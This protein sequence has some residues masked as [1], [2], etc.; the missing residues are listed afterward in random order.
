[1]LWKERNSI[2]FAS[3]LCCRV[4]LE[5]SVPTAC[6]IRVY[7]EV[8]LGV[9]ISVNFPLGTEKQDP[10]LLSQELTLQVAA[11]GHRPGRDRH[12]KKQG[13]TLSK[14]HGK[15]FQ[16]P[17]SRFP[18]FTKAE[19]SPS[20]LTLPRNTPKSRAR[21][22][23]PRGS[24]GWW[25]GCPVSTPQTV[26]VRLLFSVKS[27]RFQ[28]TPSPLALPP[29]TCPDRPSPLLALARISHPDLRAGLR[30]SQPIPCWTPHA[31]TS[32]KRASPLPRLILTYGIYWHP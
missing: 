2:G 8:T 11:P 7:T 14:K 4:G 16:V 17:E 25:A 1:M 15:S 6:S 31:A 20:L 23:R 29:K 3:V 32:A 10:H 27:A 24:L 30:V 13:R 19:D 21:T 12:Q 9:H 22:G 5:H 28:Q 18:I 26:T